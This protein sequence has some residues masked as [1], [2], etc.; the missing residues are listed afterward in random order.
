MKK[1]ERTFSNRVRMPYQDAIAF[2][3]KTYDFHLEQSMIDLKNKDF[4]L[5]QADRFKDWIIDMKEFIILNE[6]FHEHEA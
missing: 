6:S 4:H 2:A 1:T 3:Q 5:R